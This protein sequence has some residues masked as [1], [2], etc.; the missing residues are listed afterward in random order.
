[1]DVL[2]EI[3]KWYRKEKHKET[4]RANMD[5]SS[6]PNLYRILKLSTTKVFIQEQVHELRYVGYCGIYLL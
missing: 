6:I 3:A 2:S 4:D 1:M 5:C